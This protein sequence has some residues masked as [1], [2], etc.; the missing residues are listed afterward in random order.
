MFLFHLSILRFYWGVF[1]KLL[2][3]IIIIQNSNINYYYSIIIINYY[4]IQSLLLLMPEFKVIIWVILDWLSRPFEPH[5]AWNTNHRPRR[6]D[7]DWL[8]ATE[9][10]KILTVMFARNGKNRKGSLLCSLYYF[11]INTG[12]TNFDGFKNNIT[13]RFCE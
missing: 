5:R 9:E 4:R 10:R 2:L 12:W 7:P 11:Q 6:C 13:E 3:L 1:K 8:V